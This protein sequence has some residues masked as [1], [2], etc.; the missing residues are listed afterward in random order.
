MVSD[1][2]RQ[3]F[4]AGVELD[5]AEEP[6]QSH[7][8]WVKDRSPITMSLHTITGDPEYHCVA[9]VIYPLPEH[10]QLTICVHTPVGIRT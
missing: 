7:P 8:R 5:G 10:T 2:E 4:E 3:G 9:V 1:I 6:K